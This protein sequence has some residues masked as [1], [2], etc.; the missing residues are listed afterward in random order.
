MA[1]QDVVILRRRRSRRLEGRAGLDPPLRR[2][3]RAVRVG[4]KC[5]VTVG[6]GD[7]SEFDLVIRNGTVA[8]AADTTV[9]DV[10]IRD[11]VVATLGKGLGAGAREIDAAGHYVLP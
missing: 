8:T 3:D 7:M 10:G 2:D 9:C 6:S 5:R 1:L 11:G 4:Y